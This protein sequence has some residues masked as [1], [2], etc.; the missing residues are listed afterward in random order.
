[1]ENGVAA[2]C[3]E[4]G[5][6]VVAYSPLGRGLLTGQIKSLD[7]I[8][9]NSMLRHFP[10]FQPD[11]F[12]INL[13]LARQVETIAQKKGCTPSQLAINW[14]RAVAKRAGTPIIPIPGATTADRVKENAVVLDL[15]EQ[16]L[17]D[18]DQ[19]LSKFEG[20]GAR[21]PDFI[22]HNT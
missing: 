18:L 16:D 20:A 1:L 11:T 17:S 13:E 15:T 14:T 3:A 22:P 9:A 7:D 2:A 12:P 8:P 10:R 21:Y 4:H 19:I 6:S 5:I